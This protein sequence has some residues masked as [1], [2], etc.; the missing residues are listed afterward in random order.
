[1]TATPANLVEFKS[2]ADVIKFLATTNYFKMDRDLDRAIRHSIERSKDR[3][4]RGQYKLRDEAHDQYYEFLFSYTRPIWESVKLSLSSL[5]DVLYTKCRYD[6]GK[7]LEVITEIYNNWDRRF[8][9]MNAHIKAYR[10]AM[11]AKR[12]RLP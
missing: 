2:T 4:S 5:D 6:A 3:L 9:I 1:M 12:P 10:D 11:E 8:V 7:R